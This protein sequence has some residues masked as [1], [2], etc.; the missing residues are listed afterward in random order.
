[1]KS[2]EELIQRS[3][4]AKELLNHYLI[5]E[6]FCDIDKICYDGIVSS[7]ADDKQGRENLYFFAKSSKLLKS[8]FDQTI[9]D[10]VFKK[11]FAVKKIRNIHE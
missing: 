1:M 4:D 9:N 2:K 6:F 5:K 11:E 8:L 3:H 10:G 7:N